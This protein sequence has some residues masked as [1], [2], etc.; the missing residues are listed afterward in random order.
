MI[1][2]IEVSGMANFFGT[3]VSILS[4]DVVALVFETQSRF[5]CRDSGGESVHSEARE[6]VYNSLLTTLEYNATLL[7]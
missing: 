6:I 7:F 3:S 4:E 1:P 2:T 5:D